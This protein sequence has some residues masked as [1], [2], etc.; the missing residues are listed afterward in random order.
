MS[1]RPSVSTAFL[2]AVAACCVVAYVLAG[3]ATET[4]SIAF[5]RRHRIR[6]KSCATIPGNSFLYGYSANGADHE[7]AIEGEGIYMIGIWKDRVDHE[8]IGLLTVSCYADKLERIRSAADRWK[9]C[10]ASTLVLITLGGTH[11][12][13]A[14]QKIRFDISHL[15][16]TRTKRFFRRFRMPVFLSLDHGRGQAY[17]FV[18]DLVRGEALYEKTGLP[19]QTTVTEIEP[20]ST[21]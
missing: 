4:R 13:R 12:G 19:G 3:R 18:Y 10:G 7:I 16:D 2:C 21:W 5:R 6:F 14:L 17:T 9:R 8:F 20:R 1:T 15:D 11:S